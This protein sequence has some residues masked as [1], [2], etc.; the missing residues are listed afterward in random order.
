MKKVTQEELNSVINCNR[1]VVLVLTRNNCANC[2]SLKKVIP[3]VETK[4]PTVKFIEF[5]E[6]ADVY[7]INELSKKFGFKT[8]PT[9]IIYVG[10]EPKKAIKG[11]TFSREFIQE[12]QQLM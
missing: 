10:G 3:N 6:L 4:L 8:V 7:P 5:N 12:I 9:S 2:D 11:V 1:V